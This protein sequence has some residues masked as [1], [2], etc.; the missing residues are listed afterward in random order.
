MD[1]RGLPALVFLLG[2]VLSFAIGSSWGTM[3]LLFREGPPS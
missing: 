2:S 1:A 3:A